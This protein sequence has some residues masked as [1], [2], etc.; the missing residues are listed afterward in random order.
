L[1]GC[2]A[3]TKDAECDTCGA[4]YFK[5]GKLCE[6][7]TAASKCKECETKIGNCKNCNTKFWKDAAVDPKVCKACIANCDTCT[8]ATD[9]SA[10][11][12]KAKNFATGDV[13][14]YI[15]TTAECDTVSIKQCVG[16]FAVVSKACTAVGAKTVANCLIY[17]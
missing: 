2:A 11:T 10:C 7:C 6:P 5:V 16:E 13:V 17:H 1:T 12:W 14:T 8:T 4:G 9:C 15:K 3:C